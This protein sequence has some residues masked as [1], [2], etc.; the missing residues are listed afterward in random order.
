MWIQNVDQQC[1][2]AT[3]HP[4][5]LRIPQQTTNLQEFQ[6]RSPILSFFRLIDAANDSLGSD[7]SANQLQFIK[8]LKDPKAKESLKRPN[9]FWTLTNL[10]KSG[11]LK[12]KP[13]ICGGLFMFADGAHRN[14]SGKPVW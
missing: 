13:M 2:S 1:R 5:I 11:N 9:F 12:K 10:I 4:Y 3:S 14:C 6:R 7:I 8:P